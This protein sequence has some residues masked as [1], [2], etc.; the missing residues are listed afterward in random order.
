VDCGSHGACDGGVCTC[1]NGYSGEHCETQ[2]EYCSSFGCD[3]IPDALIKNL[4]IFESSSDGFLQQ[5]NGWVPAIAG[6]DS[7]FTHELCD[8]TF[9]GWD[10]ECDPDC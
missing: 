10:N 5:M 3:H 4:R 8:A 9:S 2:G 6:S 1:T 7:L